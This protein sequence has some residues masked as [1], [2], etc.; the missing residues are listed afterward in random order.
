MVVEELLQLLIREVDAQLLKSVQV[1][2]LESS[3]VKHS[4]ETLSRQVSVQGLV[5]TQDQ[6]ENDVTS[7]DIE[8]KLIAELQVFCKK[9]E[10]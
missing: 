4:D 7:R 9:I 3:D 1:E 6:P 5:H 8:K 10:L 2:D